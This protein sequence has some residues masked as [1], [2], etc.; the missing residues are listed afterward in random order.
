M[1][2]ITVINMRSKVLYYLHHNSRSKAIENIAQLSALS[3]NIAFQTLEV[4][5]NGASGLPTA[6]LC[7]CLAV[8]YT[9]YLNFNIQALLTIKIR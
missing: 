9:V 3:L 1:Q 7:R 8:T 5:Y 4:K 6:F 2:K